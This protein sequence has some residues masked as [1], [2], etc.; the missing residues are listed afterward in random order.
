MKKILVIGLLLLT[1]VGCQKKIVVKEEIDTYVKENEYITVRNRIDSI[2]TNLLLHPNQKT[3]DEFIYYLRA[4]IINAD[5]FSSEELNTLYN[6]LEMSYQFE[7]NSFG[8]DNDD[9]NN[10]LE[11][12]Q[13]MINKE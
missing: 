7:F 12:I 3:E 5:L 6:K 1:V 13:K 2:I 11:S 9:Y 10:D 8:Y 4:I